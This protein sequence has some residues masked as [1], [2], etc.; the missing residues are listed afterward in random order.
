M[1]VDSFTIL[2]I[3][4]FVLFEDRRQ[5][6]LTCQVTNDHVTINTTAGRSVDL[7]DLSTSG[8]KTYSPNRFITLDI[9]TLN[10][11]QQVNITI[12]DKWGTSNKC[13]LLLYT[14]GKITSIR[15]C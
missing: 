7:D 6:G 5:P 3:L 9:T 15:L 12:Q 10:Q 13:T 4:T 2:L 8:N 11:P 14:K 1:S